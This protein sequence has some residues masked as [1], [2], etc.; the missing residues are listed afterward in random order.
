ML[1]EQRRLGTAPGSGLDGAAARAPLEG[2][3][4]ARRK[5]MLLSRQD[6]VH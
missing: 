5:E 4:A 3:R 1:E 2:R 6:S